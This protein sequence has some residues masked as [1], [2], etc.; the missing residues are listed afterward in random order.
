[1][2]ITTLMM[3]LALGALACAVGFTEA[4]TAAPAAVTAAGTPTAPPVPAG[5]TATPS[6]WP[7]PWAE[8][9]P[10]PTPVPPVRVS[11]TAIP[12]TPTALAEGWF[13]GAA[14]PDPSPNC[15]DH[16][17][18][19]FANPAQGNE[20]ATTVLNT[21]ATLQRFERGLMLWTQEG[22]RTYVLI[23]DGSPFR[24]YVP[25]SDPAGL[26]FPAPDP[27]IVPPEGFYQPEFG[28]A[29]FWRGLVPGSE[30]VR[31]ALGWA[32]A[33]EVSYSSFWQCNTATGESAR[34]YITGPRDEIL[35]LAR[36]P[37]SYW[38]WVQGPVR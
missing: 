27:A 14:T 19:F 10:T 18:W 29:N 38:A 31:P 28:F 34:C 11:P 17:P 5:A 35:A 3:V 36:G 20:C 8:A 4:P 26:P 9:S 22:G 16:Y 33:P 6:P 2:R 25:V 7:E 12:A 37:A 21:W 32:T 30:W 1:M 23:D 24:P 15:P 13:S